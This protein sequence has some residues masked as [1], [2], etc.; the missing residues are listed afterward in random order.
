[1]NEDNR[2]RVYFNFI[3][4]IPFRNT[5]GHTYGYVTHGCLIWLQIEPDWHQIE[6]IR[7]FSRRA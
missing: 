7:I 4:V 1:M 5:W 3:R 2:N 6:Q